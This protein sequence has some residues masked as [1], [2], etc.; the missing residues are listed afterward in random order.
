MST[1]KAYSAASVTAPLA[2]TM[3]RREVTNRDVQIEILFC[4]MR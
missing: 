1:A 3:P 4:G 2:S